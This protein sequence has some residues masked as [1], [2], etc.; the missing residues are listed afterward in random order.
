MTLTVLTPPGEEA[1]SLAAAKAFLRIGHDGEDTLVAELAAGATARLEE[2]AGLA[3]VTRT[4]RRSF[5]TWPS[6]VHRRGITP[7]PG[8]ASTLVAVRTADA[9]ETGNDLTPRFVL[10]DDRACLRPGEY[11][12]GLP[13]GAR[14]E[15]DFEAGFGAAGDIPGD[16]VHALKLILLDAYRRNGEAGLPE[17][18][19]AIIAARREVLI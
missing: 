1:L 12:P 17:E 14:V 10:Q 15:I 9:V 13:A 16:L 6:S 18:A 5:Y 8:P 7:R 3:L 19:R 11:L 2:A 4:L